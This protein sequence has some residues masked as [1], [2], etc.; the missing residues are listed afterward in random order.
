M[1]LD[2][3]AFE[4]QTL[5]NREPDLI[6]DDRRQRALGREELREWDIE[7]SASP[8]GRNFERGLCANQLE[9]LNEVAGQI[10]LYFGDIFG[11]VGVTHS[12]HDTSGKRSRR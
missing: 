10:A 11:G 12:P 3:F 9:N 8:L 4:P 6:S 5:D 7:I 1:D 2:L